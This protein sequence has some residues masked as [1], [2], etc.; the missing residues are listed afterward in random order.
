MALSKSGIEDYAAVPIDDPKRASRVDLVLDGGGDEIEIGTVAELPIPRTGGVTG[1]VDPD[2]A[3]HLMLSE[4][5]LPLHRL[6]NA[7]DLILRESVSSLSGAS[8]RAGA[9]RSAR[10]TRLVQWLHGQAPWASPSTLLNVRTSTE[11]RIVQAGRR[12]LEDFDAAGTATEIIR[13][14]QQDRFRRIVP[15]FGP[16]A[17]SMERMTGIEPAL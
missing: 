10:L 15:E 16:G 11:E 3:L 7:L 4:H 2:A 9:L 8:P 5:G 17:L 14:L 6:A 13:L 12:G 1:T